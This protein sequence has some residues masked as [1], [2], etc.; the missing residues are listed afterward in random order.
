MSSNLLLHPYKGLSPPTLKELR[1]KEKEDKEKKE[2]KKKKKEDK[3]QV[4]VNLL[5]ESNRTNLLMAN[6][7]MY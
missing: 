1:K 6:E 3:R 5:R 7:F 4:G 2:D